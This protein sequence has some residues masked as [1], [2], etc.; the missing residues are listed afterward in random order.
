MQAGLGSFSVDQ[1]GLPGAIALVA[2]AV[3]VFLAPV[4]TLYAYLAPL[5]S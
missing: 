5:L 2:V 4:I 3:A 1:I